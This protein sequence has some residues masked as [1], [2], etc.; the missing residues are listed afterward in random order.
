[1]QPQRVRETYSSASIEQWFKAADANGDGTL[2]ANEFFRWSL[3]NASKK[4]GAEALQTTFEKY[5]AD[6]SG[7][8]THKEFVEAATDM[9]F[10]GSAHEIFRA[11]DH[12]GGGSISYGELIAALDAETPVDPQTKNML[13]AMVWSYDS[14]VKE[15]GHKMLVDTSHW[16][17]RGRDAREVR[18][19]LQ[20]LLADSG[21]HVAD[22][23]K[24]FDEDQDAELMIDEMEFHTAMRNKFGYQ[25]TSDTIFEVFRSLD[26]DGSGAIGYDEL[27]E[28]IRGK[29]HSL[30]QRTKREQHM[31]L[32]APPGMSLDTIEWGAETLRILMQNMLLRC[33]M[34]PGELFRAWDRD[35]DKKLTREE[36]LTTMYHWFFK[37]QKLDL[38]DHDVKPAASTA[39]D[40][41]TAMARSHYHS[42]E[43]IDVN[44]LG[45]WIDGRAPPGTVLRRKPRSMLRRQETR[46]LMAE[47]EEEDEGPR[48]D[49]REKTRTDL[50][51]AAA[52]GAAKKAA[53]NK[54]V[55]KMQEH[56]AQ[57]WD[58][59]PSGGIQPLA[60]PRLSPRSPRKLSPRQDPAEPSRPS[61]LKLPAVDAFT[62]GGSRF[63]SPAKSNATTLSPR[64]PDLYGLATGHGPAS[65]SP[66]QK[67]V[68]MMMLSEF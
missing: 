62:R 17:I 7:Q 35:G 30:D 40:G 10:G 67:P 60:S 1:M 37:D 3:G 68:R 6:G 36:F 25:G 66:R 16:V 53:V 44:R 9:G 58:N 59:S 33:N 28:F 13:M 23:I 22:L 26:E 8:L 34:G 61:A 52:K 29:R 50:A 21:Y 15:E 41:I 46:R 38:W 55:G 14:E 65:D 2:S 49:L 20:R 45:R 47:A 42:R 4:Y 43:Y 11:L 12:D 54:E 57:R 19:Q 64:S 48:I 32:E 51:A 18:T 27:Y 24:L 63:T 5:D 56:W 31:K 39:F